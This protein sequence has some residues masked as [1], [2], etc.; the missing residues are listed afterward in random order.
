MYYINFFLCGDRR[1]IH[2]K[3]IARQVQNINLDIKMKI[4]SNTNGGTLA[5]MIVGS[6]F[7]LMCCI[8]IVSEIIESPRIVG[9]LLG[10]AM[11]IGGLLLS[12]FLLSYRRLENENGETKWKRVQNPS[13]PHIWLL[14][15]IIIGIIIFVWVII[16]SNTSFKQQ[17]RKNMKKVWDTH[18]HHYGDNQYKVTNRAFNIVENLQDTNAQA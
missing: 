17:H 3:T 8:K 2:D 16:E 18:R 7:L 1:E 4:K 9:T 13:F 12:Y 5:L 6:V 14:F 15:K 11:L 10:F